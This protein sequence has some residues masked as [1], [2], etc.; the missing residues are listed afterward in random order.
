MEPNGLGSLRELGLNHFLKRCRSSLPPDGFDALQA[1]F[2]EVLVTRVGR[3]APVIR[4]ESPH[5]AFPIMGST[6]SI[7][8]NPILRASV[9]GLESTIAAQTGDSIVFGIDPWLSTGMLLADSRLCRQSLQPGDY[10]TP[11]V[12][13]LEDLLLTTLASV[14]GPLKS[15]WP[16]G[17][18]FAL[19]LSH[20]VDRIRKTFQR[21]TGPAR[22]VRQGHF[23]RAFDLA[24]SLNPDAYW[25][26]DDILRLE[27]GLD[28]RSTFFF[29]HEVP[30]EGKVSWRNRILLSGACRLDNPRVQDAVREIGNS[31]WGI[32][33]HSS[34]FARGDA[35][36]LLDEK[37][38]LEKVADRAVRGVRQHFLSKDVQP[39]WEPQIGSG[40][41]F[42][43]TM[44]FSDRLGFRGGTSFPY[45]VDSGSSFLEI[46]FQIMDGALA[47]ADA[48]SK[49]RCLDILREV[50]SVGGLLVLLWHQRFFNDTEFPGFMGLYEW[51]VR[52]ARKRGAWVASLEEVE[53][54]WMRRAG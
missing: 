23:G 20:D 42:D 43:S 29:L 38:I 11:V 13:Q 39:L 3:A 4:A 8:G 32:G 33:L 53:R 1:R 21:F 5:L 37:T 35:K 44:G 45:G 52:E 50:E 36:R 6:S 2:N 24:T 51:L 12:D 41:S 25:C 31:G 15:A 28:A 30:G 16:A 54:H 26:F 18:P 40:F 9:N 14:Y 17:S 49:D 19:G 46:P 7:P 27:R 34:S 10:S 48:A 22:E 47:V